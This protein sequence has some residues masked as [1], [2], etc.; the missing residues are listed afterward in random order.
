MHRSFSRPLAAGFVLIVVSCAPNAQIGNGNEGGDTSQGGDGGSEQGGEGG[1]GQA[2]QNSAGTSGAAGGKGGSSGGAP[3]AG[4]GGNGTTQGTGGAANGG[5]VGSA[6]A[7]ACPTAPPFDEADRTL[8]E[9]CTQPLVAAV[10][11]GL[12]RAFSFDG[13]TWFGDVWFPSAGDDQNEESHRD[14]AIGNGLVVMVG[15]GGIFISR[16][17]GLTFSKKDTGRSL[18]SSA[19]VFFKGAFVIA[20]YGGVHT[21]ADGVEWKSWKEDDML[22]GGLRASFGARDGATDGK[23]VVFVSGGTYRSY[24]GETWSQANIAGGGVDSLTFANGRFAGVGSD[25]SAVS[26]NGSTWS[27]DSS[28]SGLRFDTIVWNGT[29]FFASGSQYDGNAQTSPD[30]LA[31]TRHK[32]NTPIGPVTMLGDVYVGASAG[33]L[34]RSADGRSWTAPHKAA[35]DSNW[36][37]T[38]L[39]TG[40]V[41]KSSR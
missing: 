40:P 18:H 19:V 31:W 24:D 30:G 14:V 1:G 28:G 33:T 12:R 34:Y 35:G 22:P 38:R 27:G 13:Q 10:G 32:M 8:V 21:S 15:D 3:G 7:G 9:R 6:M 2:T 5:T 36:G 17:A 11:N 26:T 20:A 39:A 25:S 37:F 23:K 29:K 41:L 4:N 16:D